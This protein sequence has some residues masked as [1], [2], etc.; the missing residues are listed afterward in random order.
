M[1]AEV[2]G[3]P[4]L[5]LLKDVE[6]LSQACD[7]LKDCDAQEIFCLGIVLLQ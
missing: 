3:N 5:V 4:I 1:L 6:S 2:W 7:V